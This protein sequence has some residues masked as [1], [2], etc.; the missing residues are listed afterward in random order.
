MCTRVLK[1][2]SQ[3]GSS[4]KGSRTAARAARMSFVTEMQ[5]A[6]TKAYPKERIILLKAG[7]RG[8][9]LDQHV[10]LGRT[11]DKVDSSQ[12][13]RK[14]D[15]NTRLKSWNKQLFRE[16]TFAFCSSGIQ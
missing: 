2:S 5:H 9:A 1:E 14:Q 12:D 16:L 4:H 7:V 8:R 6:R 10:V 13:D 15:R 11:T 3:K